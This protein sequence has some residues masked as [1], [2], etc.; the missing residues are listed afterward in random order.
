MVRPIL[1]GISLIVDE[2]YLA[3]NHFVLPFAFGI[4]T[5]TMMSK[6]ISYFWDIGWLLFSVSA[7]AQTLTDP[8]LQIKEVTTGLS[9]PTAMA[10]IGPDDIPVL[11]KADGKIRRVLGGVLQTDQVLDVAV[12]NSSERGLL[13]IA[14][15]PDFPKMPFIYISVLAPGALGFKPRI[16]DWDGDGDRHCRFIIR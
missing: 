15:H 9:Q 2:I 10:F 7:S 12:D 4:T 6:R 16:G 5:T 8:A 3:W 11:Q 13:G 14:V 1:L